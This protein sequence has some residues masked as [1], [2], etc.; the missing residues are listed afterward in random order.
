MRSQAEVEIDMA[1]GILSTMEDAIG[2]LEVYWPASRRGSN[3]QRMLDEIK[4][5]SQAALKCCQDALA[6]L[7]SP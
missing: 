3:A 2:R 6:A 1:A 4:V 7:S 5:K